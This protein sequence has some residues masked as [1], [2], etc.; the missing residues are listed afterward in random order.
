MLRSG[1]D[2]FL[3]G[4]GQSRAKGQIHVIGYNFVSNCHR[5]F[6]LGSYFSL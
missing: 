5:D 6:K 4:L 3:K 2:S 1:S